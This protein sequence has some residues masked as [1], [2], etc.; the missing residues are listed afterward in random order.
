VVS[1]K[2]T[3][4]RRKK[5]KNKK[6]RNGRKNKNNRNK[7]K[8][9]QTSVVQ[10]AEALANELSRQGKSAIGPSLNFL[11]TSKNPSTEPLLPQPNNPKIRTQN[12]RSFDFRT[13]RQTNTDKVVVPGFPNGLPN[14]TPEGVKI[15]LASAE[16]GIPKVTQS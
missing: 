11:T 1:G 5:N 7:K 8:N 10:N 4:F 16:R 2:K 14:G 12:S 6:N 3:L 9:K 15:A 13:G